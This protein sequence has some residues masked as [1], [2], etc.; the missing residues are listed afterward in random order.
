MDDDALELLS[1]DDFVFEPVGWDFAV[2]MD[3]RLDPV[4]ECDQLRQL[5]DAMLV[6]M[7]DGPELERLTTEAMEALWSDGL[8]ATIREGVSEVGERE[9]W[10][11]G[12]A[13][14]LAQFG[15]D[16]RAAEVSREAVRHLAMQR[17]NLDTPT[18]FCVHCLDEACGSAEPRQR[19]EIALRAAIFA[20]RDAA[21][22]VEE[23]ARVVAAP[24][25]ADELGTQERRR[26]VRR[27]LGRLAA[28]GRQSLPALAPELQA[29]AD[30]PLPA[31]A[32]DDDV[33]EVVCGALL[34]DVAAPERN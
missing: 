21:V 5:A 4:D 16:A 12:A 8:A 26:A 23:L 27:R 30:E 33:W 22:P 2:E 17:S 28:F 34:A 11:A 1:D 7:R 9:E 29:I 32:A 20:R 25:R 3:I 13:A 24:A 19:R 15:R 18:F 31:T 6:G 14:A 10:R